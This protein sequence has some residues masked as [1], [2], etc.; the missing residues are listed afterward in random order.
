MYHLGRCYGIELEKT[1]P[2]QKTPRPHTQHTQA[3]IKL[4]TSIYTSIHTSNTYKHIHK[5]KQKQNTQTTAEAHPQ[6]APQKTEQKKSITLYNSKYCIRVVLC[7]N[8]NGN[9]CSIVPPHLSCLPVCQKV[10]REVL[11]RTLALATADIYFIYFLGDTQKLNASDHLKGHCYLIFWVFFMNW[12]APLCRKV[13]ATRVWQS[14]NSSTLTPTPTLYTHS[15][16]RHRLT[17]CQSPLS[18]APHLLWFVD[19]TLVFVFW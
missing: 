9:F 8:F 10:S 7:K 2:Q 12:M 11:K 19:E 4:H 18:G 1:S 5:T 17:A 6:T 15:S 13:D 3:Y 14:I 16:M